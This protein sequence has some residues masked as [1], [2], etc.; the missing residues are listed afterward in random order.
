MKIACIGVVP[1]LLALTYSMPLEDDNNDVM[2]WNH[3]RS[4]ECMI[5]LCQ[6]I[7]HVHVHRVLVV[8]VQSEW[9]K[10]TSWRATYITI[11][12]LCGNCCDMQVCF[13]LWK[14]MVVIA[15]LN[16]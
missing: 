2:E 16:L 6:L 9:L 4:G 7:M 14:K 3:D 13:K 8:I 12:P 11:I 5:F 10:C 15:T 1:L